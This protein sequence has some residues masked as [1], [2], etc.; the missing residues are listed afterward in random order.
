LPQIA[1][2]DFAAIRMHNQQI[3]GITNEQDL[4][5]LFLRHWKHL[6]SG[7]YYRCVKL[8][9][10]NMQVSPD[11]DLL[12]VDVNPTHPDLNRLVGFELKVLNCRA[13]GKKEKRQ[14]RISLAPFY[15]GLGQ[16]LT[17]FEHG[18]DRA[19]LIVGFSEEC[20][21]HSEQLQHAERLLKRHCSFLSE[22]V[23]LN[24]PAMQIFTIKRDAIESLLKVP[25]WSKERFGFYS[26]DEKLSE[27]V[28]LRRSNLLQGQVNGRKLAA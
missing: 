28:K 13:Y 18:L 8:I 7:D 17:Y 1:P 22:S 19:A 6:A 12:A 21:Q 16:V 9:S 24:F 20:E 4:G 3:V 10:R 25:N 5:D 15:E 11:I 26:R 27:E 14:W 2:Y 23:L